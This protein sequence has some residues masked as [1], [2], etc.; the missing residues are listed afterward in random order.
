MKALRLLLKSVSKVKTLTI[1]EMEF[2]RIISSKKF[3]LMLAIMLLPDIIYLLSLG[4]IS[5]AFGGTK[6][7]LEEFWRQAGEFILD[8][9]TGIPAQ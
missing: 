7:C 2:R 1:A 5:P 6:V 4:N 8:F 9:W 3:K